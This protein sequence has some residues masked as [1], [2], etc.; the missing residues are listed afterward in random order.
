MLS[1]AANLHFRSVMTTGAFSVGEAVG[2]GWRTMKSKLGLFVGAAVITCVVGLA[3]SGVG[4]VIRRYGALSALVA[5]ASQVAYA[6]L[7]MSWTRLSLKVHDDRPGTL[8]EFVPD[9]GRFLEYLA[10]AFLYSLIVAVGLILFVVPGIYWGVRLSMAGFLV[11]DRGLDPIA[12]LHESSQVTHGARW[13][14]FL[15]FL[16]CVGLNLLGALALGIGLLF[17]IPATVMA[18]AFTYRRLVARVHVSEPFRPSTQPFV[19]T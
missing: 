12:A 7:W 8:E 13:R 19:P 4:E 11:V 2:Y 3:L 18:F 15:L 6:W 17:T 10:T 16:A 9:L 1:E 14:L 5:I